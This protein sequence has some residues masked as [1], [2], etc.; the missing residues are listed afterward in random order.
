MLRTGAM[1]YLLLGVSGCHGR[2]D[3]TKAGEESSGTLVEDSGES[4]PE[5]EVDPGPVET[6]VVN[7]TLTAATPRG[8]AV[9]T[10]D[11]GPVE[12]Y[13][14]GMLT[15]SE[16]DACNATLQGRLTID[17]NPDD[18]ILDWVQIPAGITWEYQGDRM[19]LVSIDL[20][21]SLQAGTTYAVELSVYPES[22]L[23]YGAVWTWKTL[24]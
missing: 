11:P 13:I 7:W 16:V 9:S 17:R 15:Q 3:V 23:P 8:D 2:S 24:P 5:P 14:S 4:E 12:A 6:C 20:E 22:G 18:A 21:R 1:V 10:R 19:W